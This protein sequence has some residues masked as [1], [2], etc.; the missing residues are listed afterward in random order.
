MTI[1]ISNLSEQKGAF[2]KA[3]LDFLKGLESETTRQ[4]HRVQKR[5]LKLRKSKS[6]WQKEIDDIREKARK[7]RTQ[8]DPLLMSIEAKFNSIMNTIIVSPLICPSCGDGDKGNR[9]NGKP[10][11]LKCNSPLLAREK[12]AKYL[13]LPKIKVAKHALKDELKRL[14]PRLDPKEENEP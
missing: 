11:C 14:N 5:K 13:K 12:V 10:W 8:Y 4:T 7:I 1:D 6:H 2:L 3:N 9:M